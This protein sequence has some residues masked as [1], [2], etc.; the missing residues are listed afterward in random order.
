MVD[1]A[2][3]RTGRLQRRVRVLPARVVVYLLLAG[4]LFAELGYDRCG[5]G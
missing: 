3:A 1:D 2:L 5:G 4:G